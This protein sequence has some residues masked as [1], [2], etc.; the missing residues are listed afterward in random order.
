MAHDIHSNKMELI[1][2]AEKEIEE[3]K[4]DGFIGRIALGSLWN[5]LNA[6][7]H[8]AETK[9]LP[10]SS[11]LSVSQLKFEIAKA[12]AFFYVAAAEYGRGDQTHALA[13]AER[14]YRRFVRQLVEIRAAATSLAMLRSINPAPV[15]VKLQ[16]TSGQI[17]K[18]AIAMSA[19]FADQAPVLSDVAVLVEW[20]RVVGTII[21]QLPS[22]AKEL[23][24]LREAAAASRSMSSKAHA[25]CEKIVKEIVGALRVA[26]WNDP[27]VLVTLRVVKR[28][29]R[30]KKPTKAPT[31]PTSPTSPTPTPAPTPTECETG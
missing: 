10:S 13:G 4:Y 31:S 16:G 20:Q 7:E 26:Y 27:A 28:P 23:Q 9:R 22:L 15:R 18:Q 8:L 6:I 30:A 11:P 14:V 3:G 12:L 29:R 19:W 21:E 25:A 17:R 5:T 24:S 2:A 1:T